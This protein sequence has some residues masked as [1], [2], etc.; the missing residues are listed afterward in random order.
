MS[1]LLHA[2]KIHPLNFSPA[3]LAESEKRVTSNDNR[4]VAGSSP[5]EAARLCTSV[6]RGL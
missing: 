3:T 6:G 5:V 2:K 4:V 1:G